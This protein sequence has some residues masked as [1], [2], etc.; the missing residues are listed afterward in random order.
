MRERYRA[1]PD[2]L[3][4]VDAG[5][6]PL[7]VLL[8]PTSVVAKAWEQAERVGNR[9]HWEPRT[10]VV[11]GA[12]PIGL[13]AALIGVQRGLEVHVIDQVTEGIKPDLVRPS[14]RST[15][16]ARSPT[17]A[18][19]RRHDRVHRRRHRSSSTP[20]STSGRAASSA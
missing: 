4:K 14:V 9:A 7:G 15:T 6:G 10:A 2:A 3:V 13:L 12:G 8:E 18:R 16:R 20:S 1:D 19:T 11:T 17:P 5:S